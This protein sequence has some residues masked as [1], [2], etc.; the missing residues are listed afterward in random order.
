[1]N[2]NSANRGRRLTQKAVQARQRTR[3]CIRQ[4]FHTVMLALGVTLLLPFIGRTAYRGGFLRSLP[5]TPVPVQ[6]I[7]KKT[8]VRR[9]SRFIS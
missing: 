2:N 4:H 1:M 5:G 6:G 3:D 9:D 7:L 8:S